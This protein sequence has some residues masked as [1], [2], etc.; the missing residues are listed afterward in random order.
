MSLLAPT[1]DIISGD[2][3]RTGCRFPVPLPLQHC[4]VQ[5]KGPL[6][7][8]DEAANGQPALLSQQLHQGLAASIYRYSGFRESQQE[9][10]MAM[11]V[12]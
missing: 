7:Y 9:E 2:H 10:D 4:F 6:D 8:N 1:V 3:G 11:D 12:Q 5:Y